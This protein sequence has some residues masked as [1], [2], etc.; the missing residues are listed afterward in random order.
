MSEFMSYFDYVERSSFFIV[1]QSNDA[2]ACKEK[3]AFASSPM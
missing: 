2:E 1:Q 3:E